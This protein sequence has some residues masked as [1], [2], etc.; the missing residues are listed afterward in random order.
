MEARYVHFLNYGI[1]GNALFAGVPPP[2][3]W[4]SFKVVMETHDASLEASSPS[5]G[6]PRFCTSPFE[7]T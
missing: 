3:Q 5:L 6:T 1:I 2:V 7:E 4:S